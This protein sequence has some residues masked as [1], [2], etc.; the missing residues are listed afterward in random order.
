MCQFFSFSVDVYG[1]IWAILDKKVRKE[2]WESGKNP[3][4]HS[5][6]A[7]YYGCDEDKCAKYEISI[8]YSI[9]E[10]EE[11][12][13]MVTW[14]GGMD[15]CLLPSTAVNRIERYLKEN[16]R[17]IAELF[18]AE[19]AWDIISTDLANT[20]NGNN[21]YYSFLYPIPLKLIFDGYITEDNKVMIADG[22]FKLETDLD[23]ENDVFV[24]N[25]TRYGKENDDGGILTVYPLFLYE[26]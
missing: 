8:T 19:K 1:N 15:E 24:F 4:S 17:K 12:I 26:I 25:I 5:V 2:M 7:E 14:D 22:E 6:I 13:D 23:F 16:H 20:G 21:L 3:D 18:Y 10:V 11:M 9:P